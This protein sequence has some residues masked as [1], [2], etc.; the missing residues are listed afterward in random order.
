MIRLHQFIRIQAAALSF[1]VLAAGNAMAAGQAGVVSSTAAQYAEVTGAPQEGAADAQGTVQSRGEQGPGLAAASQGQAA[2]SQGQAAASQGQA[3]ASQGQAAVSQGQAPASQGQAVA[4]QGQNTSAE[5]TSAENTSAVLPTSAAEYGPGANLP[6]AGGTGSSTG[7][8]GSAGNTS[9]R[10]HVTHRG[11]S[12]KLVTEG[13]NG[14]AN[15]QQLF[16]NSTVTML[17]SV[18][19][20][21]ILSCIIQADNGELIIVDGGLGED[22]DYLLGKIKEKGGHVSA[23]LLT[24]PHADHVGALY[25]ILQKQD[26]DYSAGAASDAGITIDKIYYNFADENW[27]RQNDPKEATMAVAVLGCLN[28]RPESM[29]QTVHKGDIIQV[30]NISVEVLN[31]RYECYTDKGNNATIV[32]KMTIDGKSLLILGDMAYEGGNR[33]LGEAGAEKLH[34]DIVQMAHHGQ[35]GVS[36]DFYRAV[37]PS[38]CMWPTPD[39]LWNSTE[40]KYTIQTTK[41]WMSDMGVNVHYCTKDGD[42]TIH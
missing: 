32:Y 5:S 11:G 22:A 4:S 15:S 3:A 29:R 28:G 26:A 18:T 23:W 25:Q 20:H 19:K 1:A 27:Y 35:N 24:H 40:S 37:S 17:K 34:S 41:Q 10:A 31:D 42:Q 12:G 14:Y 21:Q 16:Q 2:A 9:G 8:T 38:I 36:Q 39:W 13:E 30:G 7:S 6:P 33:L